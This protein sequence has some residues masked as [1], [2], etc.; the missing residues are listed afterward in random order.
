[1]SFYCSLRT[2]GREGIPFWKKIAHVLRI[3]PRSFGFV[4]KAMITKSGIP[5]D[6]DVC[7]GNII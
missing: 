7:D 4:F 1:M 5:A 6:Y 2:R 3:P